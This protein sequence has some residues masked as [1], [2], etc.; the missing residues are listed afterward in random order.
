MQVRDSGGIYAVL[1]HAHL[2]ELNPTQQEW[3][4]RVRVFVRVCVQQCLMRLLQVDFRG[5]ESHGELP[6][7]SGNHRRA[8]A[9]EPADVRLMLQA[10]SRGG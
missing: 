5:E 2:D 7:E 6:R 1:N 4:V 8:S 9:A 3:C 10:G